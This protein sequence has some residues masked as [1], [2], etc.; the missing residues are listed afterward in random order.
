MKKFILSLLIVAGLFTACSEED[1]QIEKVDPII[2]ELD[3]FHQSLMNN[4]FQKFN[5]VITTDTIKYALKQSGNKETFMALMA[6]YHKDFFLDAAEKESLAA[7]YLKI[8]DIKGESLQEQEADVLELL[9]TADPLNKY[10]QKLE[11]ETD[12][13]DTKHKDWIIIQS[14]A[15]ANAGIDTKHIHTLLNLGRMI[16]D[17]AVSESVMN[18]TMKDLK[19]NDNVPRVLIGLLLPAVQKINPDSNPNSQMLQWLDET[20]NPAVQGALDRD[21]IRRVAAMEY[22]GSLDRFLSQ[23]YAKDN[24]YF[25]AIELNHAGYE[26]MLMYIWNYVWEE[27]QPK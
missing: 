13:T 24:E 23:D 21:I 18:Q 15:A 27:N 3:N 7:A 12:A 1:P 14:I 2:I 17:P 16:Y 20:V 9:A 4:T 6:R 8:G 25:A 5:E 19:S 11:E 26:T 22:L 10:I